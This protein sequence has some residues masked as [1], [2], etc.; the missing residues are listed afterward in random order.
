MGKKNQIK[1][2]GHVIENL[3][4]DNFRVE[5][6]NGTT[7]IAYL[8]GRIRQNHI[9]VMVGDRVEMEL[10]PYDLTRGR[11]SYRYNSK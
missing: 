1:V 8:S 10:S 7:I 5:L 4:R 6:D 3:S 11:I 9:R 2:Q